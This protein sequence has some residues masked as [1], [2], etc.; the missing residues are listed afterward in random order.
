MRTFCTYC[1]CK[2]TFRATVWIYRQLNIHSIFLLFRQMSTPFWLWI[3]Q[4]ATNSGYSR[5][6]DLRYVCVWAS[7]NE[8]LQLQSVRSLPHEQTKRVA[9][10]RIEQKI[11]ELCTQASLYAF[12]L[13]YIK[14]LAS[15]YE[16]SMASC[17]RL[18]KNKGS[19]EVLI[20]QSWTCSG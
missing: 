5:M 11:K 7:A 20:P 15:L 16:S 2:Y 13:R 8:R 9:A 12:E 10:V 1:E 18:T 19:H 3:F 14:K 4:S 17:G 6:P